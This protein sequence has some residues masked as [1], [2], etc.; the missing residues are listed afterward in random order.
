VKRL[1]LRKRIVIPAV[2]L[3]LVLAAGIGAVWSFETGPRYC[4]AFIAT[5]NSSLGI[6]GGFRTVAPPC[7]TMQRLTHSLTPGSPS[8]WGDE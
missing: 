7:S 2:V 6:I 3:A 5:T 1:L 4:I 8:H